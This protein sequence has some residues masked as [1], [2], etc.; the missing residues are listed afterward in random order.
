MTDSL[1]ARAAIVFLAAIFGSAA[2]AGQETPTHSGGRPSSLVQPPV[3]TAR[4]SWLEGTWEGHLSNNPGKLEIV[5]TAP[6]AGLITGVMR[7]TDQGKILVVE[8]IS[9]VDTPAGPELRFRHFSS[10]LEA[11]ES[12][13]KQAMRLVSHEGARDVF[14]NTVPYDAKLMSTQGRK[15][16]F[17]RRGEDE[18][19]AHS[20][21]I[22]SN[23]KPAV[24]EAT[25]RRT[26]K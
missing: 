15:A 9:M 4:F 8:L 3:T 5:F 10:T 6:K 11:Y 12:E 13:F 25:Y 14:E 17:I 2:A 18:Y 1:R 24:I 16:T 19:V 22:D 7:L 21:I 20:D 26:K 23:G